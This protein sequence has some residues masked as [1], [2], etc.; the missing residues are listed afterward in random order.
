[1]SYIK[2]THQFFS[3]AN[4]ILGVSE[5][6]KLWNKSQRQIYTWA[7]D[8]DFTEHNGK[9]PLDLLRATMRRL[10]EAGRDDVVEMGLRLLTEPLGYEISR[11]DIQSDKG[12]ASL[13][14]MDVTEALGQV[15][16]GLRDI[17]EDG[18]ITEEEKIFFSSLVDRLILQAKELKDAI[19]KEMKE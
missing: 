8:P 12:S 18:E 1:M 16:S 3:A 14:L 9:N 5:M 6:V 4:T 11:M 7:A 2:K 10:Q 15:A 19:G 13:E 17:L